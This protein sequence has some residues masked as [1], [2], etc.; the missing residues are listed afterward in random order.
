MNRL[1]GKVILVTG[2]HGFIGAHLIERLSRIVD[3]KLL[4]LS[5]QARQSTQKNVI[6]LQGELAQITTDYWQSK[7]IRRIDHV[8]HLGA[9]TPKT[10][11][12]ANNISRAIDDNISGTHALLQS[13]PN[14]LVKLVFAS[15]L[16]VYAPL[17]NGAVGTESSKIMPNTL[18][19]SSKLFCEDLVTAWAKERNCNYAIL[20]YGHIYGPGEEQYG[21]LIPAVIRN[22]MANQSPVIYGDGSALRDYLYVEDAVEA[23]IRAALIEGCVDAV[24]I[25][26]GESVT[27]RD[28]V[29]RLVQLV[30]AKQKI[31]FLSEKSNGNSLRFDN[32][33]MK[34]HLGNWSMTN[35]D[36]GLAA[37]VDAFRRVGNEPQ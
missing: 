11:A 14:N 13:L 12:D 22:L 2:A 34:K 31:N 19:G 28:I 9:F 26:R 37:E 18:Y 3:V 7:D 23:T 1:E 36:D 10:S 30:G 8:F 29:Q 4:L 24:N 35:L 16:D 33:R 15:T 5:R 25:V 6:C 21:K 17:A 27:L 20:R 32:G